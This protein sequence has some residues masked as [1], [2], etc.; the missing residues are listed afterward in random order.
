M[1]WFV[2]SADGLSV[3]VFVVGF[4]I[5]ACCIVARVHSQWVV[6]VFWIG[7]LGIHRCNGCACLLMRVLACISHRVVVLQG[8]V[9]PRNS[10]IFFFF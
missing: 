2:H 6:L 8:L 7:C 1:P 4:F 9:F 10:R 5:S 3:H